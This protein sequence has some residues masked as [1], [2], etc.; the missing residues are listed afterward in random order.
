MESTQPLLVKAIACEIA[1][2]E[3]SHCAAQS[4][5]LVEF[6][7]LTQ[8]YHDTPAQ[9]RAELQK[10][11]DAVPSG[12]YDAIL[13]GYGLCSN[14]LSGL[15]ARHTRVIVP[16]AHDCITFFLGSKEAYAESFANSPGTY[17][18]TSGW[19]ECGQRRGLKEVLWG[20]PSQSSQVS[21]TS[22]ET[23]NE[24]VRKYGQEQADFLLTEMG[25]WAASY[26]H[27]NLI[28]FDFLNHLGLETQVQKICSEKGWSYVSS[29]GKL[30]LM[31][32][33]LDGPWP[34]DD[35]LTVLPGQKIAPS[36][37]ETIIRVESAA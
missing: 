10:R 18:Y 30:D 2:R 1:F 34:E 21:P 19:L 9:G 13:L 31:Q 7:F 14:I 11:I 17:Y 27:G 28:Q 36:F 3:L 4:R 22:S 33:L 23:Y 6:E 26:T 24:W 29:R 16:R 15:S 32:T 8:G 25:R 37:D 20:G 12:K 5:N 35:F